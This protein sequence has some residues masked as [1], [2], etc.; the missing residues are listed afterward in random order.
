MGFLRCVRKDDYG[1]QNLA[2]ALL[3]EQVTNFGAT[4]LLAIK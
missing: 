2:T 4:V 3:S 1:K